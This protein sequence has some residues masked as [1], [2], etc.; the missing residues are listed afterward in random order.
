[1]E[2]IV[3]KKDG[4]MVDL[5]DLMAS[6]ADQAGVG[7]TAGFV[8]GYEPS[9]PFSLPEGDAGLLVNVPL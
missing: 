9:D 4:A 2:G 6:A 5:I 7:S 3:I 1:M 8:L